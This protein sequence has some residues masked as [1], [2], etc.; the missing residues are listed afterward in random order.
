MLSEGR[1]SVLHFFGY[2]KYKYTWSRSNNTKTLMALISL[3]PQKLSFNSQ[4]SYSLSQDKPELICSVPRMFLDLEI[5]KFLFLF[6]IQV[7]C[8]YIRLIILPLVPFTDHTKLY[9]F[10][11]NIWI[12]NI[13]YPW[14]GISGKLDFYV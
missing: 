1:G 13:L 3:L 5:I 6:G 8:L 10:P 9:Y 11:L 4:C 7:K 2:R 12:I 14:W